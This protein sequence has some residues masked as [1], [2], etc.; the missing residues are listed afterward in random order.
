MK[1]ETLNLPNRQLRIFLLLCG[2]LNVVSTS[3]L[4]I[5]N[6]YNSNK[7]NIFITPNQNALLSKKTSS[8]DTVFKKQDE[9]FSLNKPNYPDL[10]VQVFHLF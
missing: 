2:T 5:Q 10:S 8:I 9:I 3:L 6:H 7:V 1:L 4:S